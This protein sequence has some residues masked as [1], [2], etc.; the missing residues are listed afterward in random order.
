MMTITKKREDDRLTVFLEGRLDTLTAPEMEKEMAGELEG[1]KDLALDIKELAYISS[2]GLR[3]L[4]KLK[5]EMDAQ[6]GTMVVS[7]ANEQNREIFDV[8]GFSDI[9]TVL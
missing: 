1:V 6:E 2:A 5:K 7:G 4:L 3:A 8:T 9:L